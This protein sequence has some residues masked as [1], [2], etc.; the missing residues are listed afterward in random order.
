MEE[1][2]NERL[3]QVQI[4]KRIFLML[5]FSVILTIVRWLM[6]AVILLQL[7]FVLVSGEKNRNI[8]S[9]GRGLAV[10]D[11]HLLL[12]LTFATDALP[13]PFS[14]WNMQAKL[15]LPDEN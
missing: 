15:Q 2:I 4:W 13:F 8:L 6:W 9:F 10:Y 1:Q 5:L 14:P 11:Y 12:Y 7:F 3:S